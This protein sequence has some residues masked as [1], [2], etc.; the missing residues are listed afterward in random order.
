MES[1]WL[2]HRLTIN[3]SL[4]TQTGR[5]ADSETGKQSQADGQTNRETDRQSDVKTDRDENYHSRTRKTEM[6]G[7]IEGQTVN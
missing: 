6:K 5:Q 3:Q 2:H 7:R 1:S 4:D